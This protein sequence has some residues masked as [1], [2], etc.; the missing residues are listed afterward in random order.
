M[1]VRQAGFRSCVLLTLATPA[2][3]QTP[4]DTTRLVDLVVTGTRVESS[5]RS[6]PAAVSV[7]TGEE[8]RARGFRF[9]LD[10]LREVP[11]ATVVQGGSFGGVTS[12]FLRGGESDYTKVLIDG[13][14]VNQPGGSIDLANLSTD[15]IERIEVVRGP[16]SVVYGSDA[17]TGVIQM[18]TRRG[19]PHGQV[20]GLAR[21][22]SFG[23]SDLRAG[24]GGSAGA[25]QWSVGLS[26]FGSQGT[27]PFNN[28]YQSWNGSGQIGL[29]PDTH[30]DLAIAARYGDS[31]TNFPTDFAGVPSDS[32]QFTTERALTLS[33]DGG[34]KLS[35]QVEL[36]TLV[37]YY[38]SWLGYDDR[39]DNPG[40]TTGYGFTALRAGHVT[41]RTLDLR[42]NLRPS[43]GLT[44]TG[45]VE[46]ATEQQQTSDEATSNFGGGPVESIDTLDR[47]R[48]NTAVYVQALGQV[49]DAVDLQ[50]GLRLDENQAF[51]T[52]LSWRGG[53]VFRP[54]AGFRMHAAA[55][56]AF[57]QPTFSEQYA[58]TPF[59]VGNPALGP[60]H[61]LS[62]EVGADGSMADGRMKLSATWFDQRFR[63]LIAYQPAAPGEPTYANIA[64][65]RARGIEI[66]GSW[67]PVASLALTGHWTWLQTSVDSTG[68]ALL[69]RPARTWRAAAQWHPPLG[70]LAMDLLY[71]GARDDMDYTAF[72]A[73][74]ETLPG[75][76]VVGLSADVPV[77]R[78]GP[79]PVALSLQVQNLFGTAYQSIVGFPGRGRTVLAG[80]R[81][82]R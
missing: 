15:A 31:R 59:E 67:S 64:G 20:Y 66:G 62:W 3:A 54:L 17:V 35:D 13:V 76:A 26:R 46:G 48:R 77:T 74:R 71:T 75:Y 28:A 14:A 49:G 78:S 36:R 19:P 55:G 27:L 16:A 45:G 42:A 6:V 51:G 65:A 38:D 24:Y 2:L 73:T 32:N 21:G 39:A 12:L 4:A 25:M 5:R 40:D 50:A 61:G 37:S 58:R 1:P 10:W 69:R 34:R 57:K 44:L 56:T 72:P 52:F 60:E 70:T 79:W 53:A 7:I 47:S 41:R 18:F 63:D 68:A 9:V 81:I 82:G 29:R 30:T 23:T 43:N 11:G 22:G 80:I 8:L 33:F